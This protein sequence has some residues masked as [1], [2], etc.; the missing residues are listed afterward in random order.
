MTER[1]SAKQLIGVLGFPVTPFRED[2]SLDL[3]G[4]QHNVALMAQH[5]FS[6]IVAPGGT[7]ELY[8]LSPSEAEL[9]VRTTVK[10][11]AGRMPVVGATGYNI[12]LGTE[13]ARTAEKA[14]ADFLLVLPPYYANASEAGLFAYYEAIANSCSLPIIIYSRDWAAFSPAMVASLAD[15]IPSL[16]AWKDGQGSARKYQRIMQHVGTRLAWLGGF[17]DECVPEYFA[18]GVQ[19]YTSGISNIAPKL[20]LALAEAG[21]KRDFDQLNRLMDRYVHPLCAI[22]ERVKGY[23]VAAM[24]YAM[25]ILGMPAGPVRPPLENVRAEDRED[26]RKLMEVYREGRD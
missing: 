20:S 12:S 17:G 3:E 25:K 18:I 11:V 21:M 8:S 24:K 9:I 13:M 22:C 16:E 26:L 1:G 23:E 2:L 14:G 4:L 7:G 19:A 6:A 10:A 5:R 15:R